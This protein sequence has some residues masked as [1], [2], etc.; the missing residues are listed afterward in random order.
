MVAN[1]NS[2]SVEDEGEWGESKSHLTHNFPSFKGGSRFDE[3]RCG[4]LQNIAEVSDGGLLLSH[5]SSSLYS[6]LS[7]SDGQAHGFEA[8]TVLVFSFL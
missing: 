4:R 6:G 8:E 7:D 2:T 5:R 3:E 1:P